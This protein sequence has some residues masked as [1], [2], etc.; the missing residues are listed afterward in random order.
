MRKAQ[1]YYLFAKK[2]INRYCIRYFLTNIYYFCHRNKWYLS[3]AE[4]NNCF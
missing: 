4:R 1:I 2:Q 3:F